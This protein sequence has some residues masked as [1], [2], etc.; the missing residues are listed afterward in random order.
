MNKRVEKMYFYDKLGDSIFI[1]TFFIFICSTIGIFYIDL[2]LYAFYL[3]LALHFLYSACWKI[4]RTIKKNIEKEFRSNF[5]YTVD[6]LS[7]YIDTLCV[8]NS[9][10]SENSYSSSYELYSDPKD[11]DV[12]SE[13][14]ITSIPP[15]YQGLKFN[16]SFLIINFD[17]DEEKVDLS[18]AIKSDIYRDHRRF[19]LD[20]LCFKQ[21]GYQSFTC[22]IVDLKIEDLKEIIK[23]ILNK[24]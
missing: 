16:P 6:E 17:V 7:E 21:T 2:F 5:S 15:E 8:A 24:V 9:L 18:Y 12:Y 19:L 1:S 11:Y 4:G 3:L 13:F 14:V 23:E 20:S 22:K 10:T